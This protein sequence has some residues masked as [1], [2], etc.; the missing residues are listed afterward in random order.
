MAAQQKQSI[1]PRWRGFNLLDMFT[2]SSD[3]EFSEDDFRWIR[4]WGF[5][6]VRIPAC[7]TLWIEDDDP[8][9]IRESGLE[10]IDRVIGLGQDYGLHVSF[11]LHRGPGYS[12]NR[13]RDEPFNLWKDRDALDAFCLH[14][15]TLAERYRGIAASDLSFDL[16]NEPPPPGEGRP[17]LYPMTR[18]DHERVVR[19]AVTTI[20]EADPDRL[21]VADG[22]GYGRIPAPELADLDLAQSCRAYEPMGVSHYRAQWVNGMDWP[23]PQ[24]P[25]AYHFGETWGRAQLEAHYDPWIEL[26]RRGVGVHCGEA[27]AFNQTPHAVVLAWFEDV[28]R[29]LTPANIGYALWNFRGPFGILDS[30]RDDVEYEQWYGHRLDREYLSLLQRY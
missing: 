12:V 18:D 21:V 5:D 14:W 24:W 8:F 10:K 28:L 3:G 15:R 25:G 2:V 9:R 1:L 23:H 20:H 27:G 6:F 19:A 26:A 16:V 17:P 22:M 29:I 13:E 4:D 11:N 30:G 7:Y